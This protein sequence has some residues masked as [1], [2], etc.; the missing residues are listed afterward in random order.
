MEP[1][2]AQ[3]RRHL[4]RRF[5]EVDHAVAGQ[6]RAQEEQAGHDRDPTGAGQQRGREQHDG[7]AAMAQRGSQSSRVPLLVS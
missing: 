5:Q 1:A 7:H 6:R 3:H 2:Q 4:R